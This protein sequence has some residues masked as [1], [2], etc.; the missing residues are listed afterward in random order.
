MNRKGFRN[1]PALSFMR[2]QEA[3]P[4]EQHEEAHE[5]AQ[6]EIQQ[7]E[8]YHAQKQDY[9]I[10]Q[11]ATRKNTQDETLVDTYEDAQEHTP[12]VRGPY[13]RTQGRKGQK[14]PRINL[15]FDSAAYLE[16]IRVHAD[17]EGKSI[18]QFVNDAVAYYL[19]RTTRE[20]RK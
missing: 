6:E 5:Y 19:E 14:K 20:N 8:L 16:T 4:E 9:E 2:P 10:A 15:A 11:E 7:K 3:A 18:T 13:V 12:V 17:R 1:S